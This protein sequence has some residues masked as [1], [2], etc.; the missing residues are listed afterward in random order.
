MR[1]LGLGRKKRWGED[2]ILE[3]ADWNFKLKIK[4]K[5]V[6]DNSIPAE[7]QKFLEVKLK[8]SWLNG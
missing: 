7:Q 2:V 6:F 4:S 3:H 8:Y 5:F 1:G